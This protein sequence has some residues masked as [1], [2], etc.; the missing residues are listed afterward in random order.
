MSNP[1]MADQPARF[2]TGKDRS[3]A[4]K[5]RYQFYTDQHGRRWGAVIEKSS[6][7]PCSLLE[8]QSWRAP[9]LAEPKYMSI[10]AEE[11]EVFIDY[12]TWIADDQQAQNDWNKLLR[13][14]AIK[15]YGQGAVTAALLDPQPELLDIVGPRPTEMK[16]PLEAAMSG[17]KW[18]LGLSDMKP[19]WAFEFCPVE[20]EITEPGEPDIRGKYPDAEVAS[21]YPKW[22]GPSK[23]WKLSDDSALERLEGEDKEAYKARAA[24]AELALHGEH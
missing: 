4:T 7:Y 19:E 1:T 23:G 17:N 11:N 15:L 16:G 13:E 12:K 9:L 22:A 14:Q 18:I 21:D 5:R 3:Q 2:D 20:T 10:D 8:P 6:G 24:Q